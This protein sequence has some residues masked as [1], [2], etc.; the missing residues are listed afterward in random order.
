MSETNALQGAEQWGNKPLM[1]NVLNIVPQ[2]VLKV[3]R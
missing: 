2:I 3:Y 1:N